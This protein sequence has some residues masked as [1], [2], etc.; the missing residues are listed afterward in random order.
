MPLVRLQ[1]CRYEDRVAVATFAFATPT[2]IR[3]VRI[4]ILARSFASTIFATTR[5]FA[6]RFESL[7]STTRRVL[8]PTP[9][10]TRAIVATI[11]GLQLS[12]LR[13]VND[14]HEF[15]QQ[16]SLVSWRVDSRKHSLQSPKE[17]HI[18][19]SPLFIAP[20]R[21]RRL[22]GTLRRSGRGLFAFARP[23]MSASELLQETLKPFE[24]QLLLLFFRP[25]L[26]ASTASQLRPE[27]L[28][29][30]HIVV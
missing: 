13:R 22:R 17:A 6:R 24:Q 11:R 19:G 21:L 8:R 16:G 1:R 14:S 12:L 20:F 5:S 26:L 28:I 30:S 23:L 27:P 29:E 10:R 3:F 18:S 4:R 25:R 15:V 2:V 9:L 7:S